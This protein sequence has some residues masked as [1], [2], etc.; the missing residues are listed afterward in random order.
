MAGLS[1]ADEEALEALRAYWTATSDLVSAG[2]QLRTGKQ[3]T[4]NTTQP[5]SI[6]SSEKGQNQQWYAPVQS[7]SPYQDYRKITIVGYGDRDQMV[8]LAKAMMGRLA[9]LP[10]K[11]VDG[12]M[13]TLAFPQGTALKRLMP[14]DDPHL[15]EDE[16]TKA[17][18]SVW[19][20]EA[21]Y[22]LWTTR[23]LP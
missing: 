1:I 18:K 12:S 13:Q 20:C 10:R 4:A 23:H 7:G 8:A 17:G 19:R 6:A 9:W 2:G 3:R 14:L 5:Y 22:E 16:T 15:I 21:L 11:V